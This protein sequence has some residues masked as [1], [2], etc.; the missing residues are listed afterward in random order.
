V[1]LWWV[2]LDGGLAAEYDPQTDVSVQER[3]RAERL[4]RPLDQSRF[5]AARAS[6]RRLAASQ[7]GCAPQ[8]VPIVAD[9]R[10]K[11]SIAGSELRFSTSRSGDVALHAFSW[12]IEVGVD[13][14]AIRATIDLDAF[15]ARFF[16]V[17]E[18]RALASLLPEQRLEA[19]FQCWTRKEAYAKGVGD[20]LSFPLRGLHVGLS[21]Y[22][23]VAPGWSVH[24]VAVAPGFAASVAVSAADHWIPTAPRVFG[25]AAPV[26][27]PAG[28]DIGGEPV[29]C[30]A[31]MTDDR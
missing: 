3:R 4:A 7:L 1:T 11:P 30:Y 25:S 8:D 12:S 9:D 14:E 23:R 18:Q 24:D 6:L 21:G 10:G 5:L 17:A 13:V 26:V 22:C 2:T 29:G 16:S 27:P 19:A 31:T 15:A 20:G 28:A